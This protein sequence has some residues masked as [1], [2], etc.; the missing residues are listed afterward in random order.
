MGAQR[1]LFSG[2]VVGVQYQARIE[3]REHNLGTGGTL[4]KILL[5]FQ[6]CGRLGPQKSSEGKKTLWHAEPLKLSGLRSDLVAIKRQS[7][8]GQ[9]AGNTLAAKESDRGGLLFFFSLG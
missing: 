7:C 8:E 2:C 3:G 5:V 4:R 6:M 9:R 1:L